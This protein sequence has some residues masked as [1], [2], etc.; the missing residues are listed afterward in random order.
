MNNTFGIVDF[1]QLKTR[2]EDETGFK[3]YE[4][5]PGMQQ[6]WY[7]TSHMF[8]T[9]ANMLND[10]VIPTGTIAYLMD[11]GVSKKWSMFTKTWY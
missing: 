1:E 3:C 9:F 11:T 6:V 10:A 8:E 2:V 4:Q 7:G 5:Q